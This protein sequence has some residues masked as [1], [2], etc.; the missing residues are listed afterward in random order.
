MSVSQCTLLASPVPRLSSNSSAL[1]GHVSSARYLPSSSDVMYCL[2][3]AHAKRRVLHA[4][5]PLLSQEHIILIWPRLK[6]KCFVA[7][8]DP[9]EDLLPCGSFSDVR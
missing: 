6:A 4:R 1:V 3:G 8:A 2:S 7:L 9:L 5:A